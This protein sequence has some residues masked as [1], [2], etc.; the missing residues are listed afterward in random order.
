MSDPLE[1]EVNIALIGHVDHGKTTLTQALS[2][3][4]T[5][6]YSEELKRGISIRLG[7][8]DA[9]IRKC[10]KCKDSD[11]FT[12]GKKCAKC[13]GKVEVS[14][15]VSFVD[16]PGHETLMATMISGAAIVDGAVLVV[17][18][19]EK[20]PQPQTEEHLEALKISD[21]KNI[22]IVQ[23]K[24][25]LVSKENALKNYQEIKAFLKS[26]GLE[27]IPIIPTAA[28][29]G[30]NIDVLIG[31][32]EEF[33]P[34]PKRDPK[35]PAVLYVARSFDI[36][37]PGTVPGKLSGG[38]IGGSLVQGSLSVGD[39]L[40][41]CPGDESGP[42]VTKITGLNTEGNSL[43]KATPGGLIGVG[44]LLDPSKTKSDKMK[45]QVAGA[46]G[47]LPPIKETL[48]F[49]FTPITRQLS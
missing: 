49:T 47:K 16:A 48:E 8:A 38:I 5:D 20:C 22:V 23:N 12:T 21:T 13:K 3:K 6:T 18:A 42:L 25:D 36:N 41:I 29:Y 14:R 10:S 27:K 2:G 26:K 11:A 35:K 37:V 4:W 32:I 45:G 46:P 44:T 40:E 30:I 34:T 17:A 7:Y 24:V 9:I 43:K 1:S 31:A 19:N 28:N 33:I 39:K 15:R